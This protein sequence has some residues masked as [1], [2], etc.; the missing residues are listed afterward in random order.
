VD[1]AKERGAYSSFK[2]SKWDQGLL[3]I[4][5]ITLLEKEREGYLEVD[6]SMRLNWEH[7]RAAIKKHGMRNSNTIAIAPT[8]TIAHITGTSPSIEPTYSNLF[9][10]S[11]LSGEFISINFALVEEL[12]ALGLWDAELLE[13][14]KYYDGSIQ[15]IEKIPNELKRL[16]KTAFE[17][18]P[19]W[20][21]ECA[22]RRQK[23]IDM[24]QSL[25]L[26]VSSPNG[27]KLNEI[28][29]LAWIKGL[30][31]TYYLRSLAATQVEKSTVDINKK[32]IQP[33]WM[34]SQSASSKIHVE[35]NESFGVSACSI[36]NP[37]C[38][39]CQ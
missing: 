28:Y 9:S 26:Y 2:G 37:E 39:S 10:R 16:Y 23:W 19:F 24:G 7:V 38:E 3:P 21:I 17:I 29:F 18:D 6:K 5:T 12:I 11:N 34:K 30:K 4:D 27:K 1:L 33:R 32:G 14:L 20:L 15:S 25:N 31:T 22:S 8:A 13:E 35:R 36:D